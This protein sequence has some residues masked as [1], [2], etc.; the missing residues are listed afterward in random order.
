MMKSNNIDIFLL[1]EKLLN[2]FLELIPQL[3]NNKLKFVSEFNINDD[4]TKKKIK[5]N[6][7][8]R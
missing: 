3:K 5:S 7:N 6:N 1:K 4:L 8:L 2:I